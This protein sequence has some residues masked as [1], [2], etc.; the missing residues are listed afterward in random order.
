MA[1]DWTLKK[2]IINR[3]LMTKLVS[4][5]LVLASALLFL[6]S[7]SLLYP[8]RQ[9]LGNYPS[10]EKTAGEWIT[11]SLKNPVEMSFVAVSYTHLD[12][13][14]RQGYLFH[15]GQKLEKTA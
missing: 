13:Y 12:V 15:K 3:S 14:K 11:I 4:I 9:K 2:K 1:S 7:F 8:L 6:P 10:S 5:I